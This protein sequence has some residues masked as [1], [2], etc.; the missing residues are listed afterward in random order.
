MLKS[1]PRESEE[2]ADNMHRKRTGIGKVEIFHLGPLDYKMP[3]W[4]PGIC[5][6]LLLEI[7]C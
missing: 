3:A 4:Q 7:W 1:E 2:L 5:Q 6:V